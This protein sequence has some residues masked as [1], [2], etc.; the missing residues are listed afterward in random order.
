MFSYKYNFMKNREG[1]YSKLVET[2]KKE[3][4]ND[5]NIISRLKNILN[6]SQQSI[7]R[8]LRGEIPFTFE[9]VMK[10]SLA[11]SFS[12]DEIIGKHRI[13]GTFLDMKW[14]L[15]DEMDIVG[16]YNDLITKSI[17][18]MVYIENDPNA[19]LIS[20]R[21]RLPLNLLLRYEN[22]TKFQYFIGRHQVATKAFNMKFSE[23]DLSPENKQMMRDYI[24]NH[25]KIKRIELIIDDN[26]LL[27]MI[28]EITYFYRRKLITDTDIAILQT[29]LFD[30]VSFVEK[31]MMEG[32][33]DLGAENICYLS[34]LDI[35]TNYSYLQ[36]NDQKIVE[37]CIYKE[38]PA[39]ISDSKVCDIMRKRLESLKKYSTLITG[40]NELQRTLYLDK[41][42]EYIE[43]IGRDLLQTY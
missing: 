25:R 7:S 1:I 10:I 11:F 27:S 26:T 20:A 30:L 6:I 2:I 12:L 39:I 13:K 41:Q 22:L 4:S 5:V 14:L 43:N 8:R 15:E 3:E 9:E 21:N 16:V 24:N 42:K 40:S 31:F 28:K 32:K 29:E 35:E 33:N 37:L 38:I 34:K 19:L 17:D 18:K 36:F 23:I